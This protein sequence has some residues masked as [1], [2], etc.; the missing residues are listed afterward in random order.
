NIE[1]EEEVLDYAKIEYSYNG[2]DWYAI[3]DLYHYHLYKNSDTVWTGEDLTWRPYS[4]Q[5]PQ[6]EDV[7]QFRWLIKNGTGATKE[8]I[9]IDKE[10]QACEELWCVENQSLSFF[11]PKNNTS[12]LKI[13]SFLNAEAET[14]DCLEGLYAQMWII[15]PLNISENYTIQFAILDSLLEED[16][17]KCYSCSSRSSIYDYDFNIYSGDEDHINKEIKDNTDNKWMKYPLKD[18]N[19]I[20]YGKGYLV[21][22]HA[23]ERGEVWLLNSSLIKRENPNKSILDWTLNHFDENGAI[24]KWEF[25]ESIINDISSVQVMNYT[26]NENFE[27]RKQKFIDEEARVVDYPDILDNI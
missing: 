16:K 14:K 27:S 21:E 19:I 8:G 24:I 6:E 25:G 9:A 17:L 20:P 18:F 12:Y 15:N 10:I 7:V 1:D 22:L 26:Y 5:I 11:D 23:K 4:L 2:K 13:N 3:P